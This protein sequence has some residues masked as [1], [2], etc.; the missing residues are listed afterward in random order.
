[1]RVAVIRN[2]CNGMIKH[3]VIPSN[4]P[5]GYCLTKQGFPGMFWIILDIKN[6]H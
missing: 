5:P 2:K 4:Y 6:V 3:V 1:M